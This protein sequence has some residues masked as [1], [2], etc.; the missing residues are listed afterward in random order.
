MTW[1]IFYCEIFC[2][3]YLHFSHHFPTIPL[4]N[5]GLLITCFPDKWLLGKGEENTLF[6]EVIIT[7]QNRVRV[8]SFQLFGFFSRTVK[9][10]SINWIHSSFYHIIQDGSW[11]TSKIRWARNRSQQLVKKASE[12]QRGGI[13]S[14]GSFHVRCP[15]WCDFPQFTDVPNIFPRSPV[16]R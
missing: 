12:V 4:S 1:K 3:H 16:K 14:L 9:L 11:Q 13:G 6:F 5:F 2:F 10:P 7:Q 15:S 8:L